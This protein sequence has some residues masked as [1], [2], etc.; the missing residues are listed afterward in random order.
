[1]EIEN[2]CPKVAYFKGIGKRIRMEIGKMPYYYQTN[3]IS[4]WE[5]EANF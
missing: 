2:K 1:M 5:T 3:T 4:I